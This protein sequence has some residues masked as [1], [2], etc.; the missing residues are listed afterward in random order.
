MA[1]FASLPTAMQNLNCIATGM[2]C[3][4]NCDAIRVTSSPG[5]ARIEI[6]SIDSPV[7]NDSNR[8]ATAY[9]LNTTDY[10]IKYLPAILI[11]ASACIVGKIM[12]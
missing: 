8:F 6:K 1:V 10:S 5:C 4:A 2:Y 7:F 9:R 3:I 11:I 12:R